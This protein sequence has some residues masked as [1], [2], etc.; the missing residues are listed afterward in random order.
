MGRSPL[1]YMTLPFHLNSQIAK[2]SSC[3]LIPVRTFFLSMV[4][5][6]TF[7]LLP[8]IYNFG[9]GQKTWDRGAGTNNWGDAN[10]WNP[11]GVP[12]ALQT[13]TISRN[14]SYTVD[15]NG[16][17][18]CSSLTISYTGSTNGTI[19]LNVLSTNILTVANGISILNSATNG[20]SNI[21]LNVADA[22]INC[23]NISFTQSTSTT[24]DSY[25]EI[26]DG[27]LYCTG[28][29]SMGATNT[30][31]YALF[32]GN[33][34]LNVGG[35]LTGGTITS[36]AGGGAVAPTSGTVDY[37]GNGA[38]NIGAYTYYNLTISGGNT[39]TLQGTTTVANNL[40]LQQG[41]LAIN[42]NTL[43]LAG[44]VT[45]GG[46]GTGTITGSATSNL[47][48]TGT[49]AFPDFY[50]TNATENLHGLTLNRTGANINLG[51]DLILS[52]TLAL[53]NGII[54]ATGNTIS[55]TNTSAA[56][57]TAGAGSYVDGSIS[58]AMTN[59]GGTYLFP[60]GA[61]CGSHWLT[62]SS[63]SGTNP[64]I[65]ATF[66]CTGAINGDA[67]LVSP[68]SNNVN[69]HLEKVSGTF[70][71]AAVKLDGNEIDFSN[72]IAQ[73]ALQ[74]G[75]YSMITSVPAIGSIT[76]TGIGAIASDKWLA[77][78]SPFIK[79][80]YSYQSGNWNTLS[81][82]T[83]DPSGTLS[84]NSAIPGPLDNVVILNGRT[85]SVTSNIKV[86]NSLEI[87]IGGN[88][89]LTTTNGHDFGTVTGQGVLKL[90]S[91]T[92]P[93]GTFTTFVAAGGGTVEY[94]NSSNFTLSPAQTIYNN[95]IINLS[96]T[97][98]IGN[99]LMSNLT[100]NGTFTV[101]QGQ[102]MIGQNTAYAGDGRV[103]IDFKQ[104]VYV[105]SNGLITVGSASTN[106]TN[107]PASFGTRP[108][109]TG[110]PNTGYETGALVPRYYDI[111][112]TIYIGGNLTNNGSVKFIS[113]TITIPNYTTLTTS[114]A[115]SVRFY[116][117]SNTSLTCNGQ[118][119]FYNLI[120]DK[121]S[122][123]TYTLTVDAAATSNFRLFG[124]NDWGGGG[125][126][127]ANNPELD[128][129][130]WIK[131][132]TLRLTGYVTIP[133]L[134]EGSCAGGSPN[135]DFYIP[136]N[137]GLLVDGPNVTVLTT[138][139]SYLEVNAAYGLNQA[140]NTYNIN[141]TAGCSSFSIYGKFQMNSGFMSTRESG[142]FIFWSNANG[143]FILNGGTIDAKQL[144]SAGGGNG[145]ASFIQSGGTLQLRGRYVIN[146][147][148]ITTVSQIRSAPVNYASTNTGGLDGGVGTFNIK[149]AN[150]LFAMSGGAMNILDVC[151]DNGN[152]FDVRSNAQNN[153]VTGGTVNIN[154]YNSTNYYINTTAPFQN[155][156][157]TR[158]A[159]AATV[160][161]NTALIINNNLVLSAASILNAQN[162]DLSIGGD[163]TLNSGCI[164]TP[165]NNTTTF[166]GSGGQVFTNAGTVTSG[167][168]NF[169]L[170]NASNT[171]IS[172]ALTVRGYLTISNN[173]CY[174][175]D[176][177]SNINVAGNILNSGTHTSQANGG[178][179]LN[180][181]GAQT[182]GGDGTGVFGNI[183]VNNAT[184]PV[185]FTANQTV[186][187][188]L[189]L[190]NGILN[191]NQYS[192]TLSAASNV[193][194]GLAGTT[195]IFSNTKM[196]TT[197]GFQSDGG[198]SK[199]YSTTSPSFVFPVGSGG[200]Y[201]PATIGFSTA[202]IT[203][204]TVNM[205][206]VGF[207]QPITTSVN[208]LKYYWKVTSSGFT[209]IQPNSV[210]HL[211]HFINP[212]DI[213]A[214]TLANYY[215]GVYNP[216]SWTV[217][218]DVS[219][220]DKINYNVKFTG[221]SYLDGDYT[222]GEPGALGTVKVYYSRKS[223]D[224]TDVNTWSSI[225]NTGAVDGTLPGIS[226]NTYNP[227][228]IGDGLSNNHTVTIPVGTNNRIVGALQINT[229]SV[230]DVTTTTGHNFGSLPNQKVTGAGT[231]RISSATNPAVFP[232]GDFGNFLGAGGG[233]V[234]YYST[235]TLG[236]TTFVLPTTYNAGGTNIPIAN[237]NHLL[238][239]PFTGK[240][241]ILPNTDLTVF[242]N[243]GVNGTTITGIAQL[244]I[245]AAHTVKVNGNLNVNSGNLRFMNN[246]AQSLIVT[247]DVTIASGAM[248]DVNNANA[249]TNTMFIQ[250]NLVN[251]GTFNMYQTATRI[252]NVTFNGALNNGISG[253][254][255]IT[256]F[257][258][259]TVNKGADRN[260]VLNVTSTN[261]SLNAALPTALTLTNGTFRLTSPLS[262]TLTTTAAFTIPASGC[263][264]ANGGTIN[265]G[266]ATNNAADLLLQGR[267]EV[268]AGA[269]NI[270]NGSGS[271]NDIEYAAA[272]NP[273][274]VVSGSGTLRVDG[275]IRRNTTN[276][277]GSL[278]YTQSGGIVTVRGLG[279]DSTRGMFEVAN[280]G[281]QFNMSGSG[282]LNIERSGSTTYADALILPASYNVTGGIVQFGN[283][284]TS[285][286]NFNL[287][288][289]S[290]LGSVIVDGTGSNKT[291]SLSV[292][293]LT[294]VNDLTINGTGSVFDCNG[295]DVNIGRNLTNNNTASTVGTIYGGYQPG[296]FTQV[297]TFNGTSAAT[298][299]GVAGNLTNFSN[300][301]NSSTSTVS[302]G[303]NTNI[304]VNTDLT[305]NS[306]ILAD[307]GNTITVI[308]NIEN[309]AIHTSTGS[310]GIVMS[311]N[312]NQVIAG[313][314]AGVFGNVTIDNAQ[315]VSMTD[316][317]TINGSLS[318]INGNLY[319]NDYLLTL[320]VSAS[321]VGTPDATKMILLNGALSD[322]GVRKLFPGTAYDFTFPVG[323]AGKYTPARFNVTSN[324][325]STGTI[326]VKPVNGKHPALQDALVNELAY[327]WYVDTTGFAGTHI[328]EH[329]YT[330][331]PA[332]IT[333]PTTGYLAGRYYNGNWLPTG[334]IIG[335]VVG[336]ST[337]SL[338]PAGVGFIGG[339]YTAGATINF[340]PMS[341][342]YSRQ[343]G[344]WE[345][346]STWFLD[347]PT[348]PTI[349]SVMPNGNQV[350]I[351]NSNNVTLSANNNSAY[352]VD[353]ANSAT[354]T[355]GTSTFHDIGHVSGGGTIHVTSTNDG[356]F[357]FPGGEYDNF[358]ANPLS[359]ITFN[360]PNISIPATMP[361][362]PGNYY[363]PYQN[364][365]FSGAGIKYIT[366]ESLKVLGNLTINGG[367]LSDVLFNRDIYVSGNW[368]DNTATGG[369]VPGTGLV[370]F[371]GT[372]AQN[373]VITNNVAENFYNFRVNNAL[374]INLTSGGAG[375]VQ[376]AN[377]LHLTNGKITTNTTNTFTLTNASPSVVIGGSSASFVNGPLY[378]TINSGSYFNFPVGNGI[379]YG[380][381]NVSSVNT[382]A[383][384]VAQYFNSLS[385]YDVTKMLTPITWVSNNE[386]W[387]LSSSATSNGNVT[388][389]W[390][391]SSFDPSYDRTKLRVVQWN[392]SGAPNPQWESQGSIINDG[393]TTSGT[394]QT[395]NVIDLSPLAN[396]HYLT[397][398]TE[399]KPTATILS[400]T[401]STSICNNATDVATVQIKLTG[402]G[403]WSL[404]YTL[405]GVLTTLTN[406]ASSPVNIAITS[407]S[408][409][410]NNIAG[411]Y[412]FKLT[413]IKDKNGIIGN[414]DANTVAITVKPVPTPSISGR[415][416]VGTSEN[417]VSYSTPS[418]VG[419]TYTWVVTGGTVATGGGTSAI[420]VNWNS[421]AGT[422][423]VQVTETNGAPNNCSIVKI[424]NV[425]KVNAPTPNV[426]GNNN[427]CA[428]A[429]GEIYST[430]NVSTHSYVWTVT[431]GSFTGPT[432]V[433]GNNQVIVSWG[434]SGVGSVKVDETYGSTI[435]STLS[436]SINA[437]PLNTP[438]VA[439]QS[440]CSGSNVTFQITGAEGASDYYLYNGAT[441]I[442]TVHTTTAGNYSF[443]AFI[444]VST[445]T[446]TV[447]VVNQYGC[448]RNLVSTP[449]VT[450]NPLPTI[451]TTGSASTKCFNTGAQT[452]TLAYTATTNSPTSYSIDWNAAAN[453]AGLADQGSTAF[454]FVAGGGS[455]N[456][457]AITAG[458]PGGS[459]SGTMTITNAN[460]C[461]NT[462]A[463]TVTITPTV[464]TP[465]FTLGATS[466]RC[467]GAGAVIYTAT[468]TN[469]TGLTY[470]LDAASLTG[471]NTIN[472]A[473]G[474]VTY[475]ASWSGT[476]II[477]ASA[478]GCNGPKTANHTVTITPTVGTPIFT[479]GPTT[480]RCRG[481][482]TVAYTV[483]ATNT[484]GI[485][486]TL[487]AAS[488]TGGNSIIAATGVVTYIAGWSGSSIITASA[489]GCNG[490]K[491]TIHTA[492]TNDDQVWT[493]AVST[494]WNT[495]GNW[496]CGYIPELTTN[497]Q[498]P[499]VLNKP[500]LG[501]GVIGTVKNIIINTGSSL[502]V[503]GNIL[504]IAGT[505]TNN[506][507][508]TATSGTIEMI[509]SAAQTIGAGVFA[510]NTIEN[511]TISNPS[512]VALSGP[513][514]VTGIV[515]ANG[516]LSS[517]GNLTLVSSATQ[518]ALISGS[519]IANVTGNVTI[520]RYLPSGFGYKYVSSP[521]QTATV[522]EF[523]PEVNLA[524]A[525]E[526]FYTYN[527]NN[528]EGGLG[529]KFIAGW[530]K[531]IVPANPLIP[532]TGYA[533]N[534]GTNPAP[535]P[536][537]ASG[538]VN[539]GNQSITLS[540]N[541][542]PFTKGFNLVG[543]PYP[544][545]I[546]WDQAT[547][548]TLTNVDKAIW[549]FN[550]STT[551]QY[552]GV[553]SSYVNGV[554]TDL[555][556]NATTTPN[557][558][559]SMQGF[560]VHVTNPGSGT[561]AMTNKV[562][563]TNLT[564]TFKAAYFDPRT[565]LRFAANFDEKNSLSDGLVIYFDPLSSV[566][567][568]NEK[569]ALKM[570]NTDLAVPNLY[571]ITPDIH[572]L[573]ISAIPSPIDSL[574]KI[575]L[576]VK[577]LKDGW[578]NF[579]ASDISQ[580]Q[581]NMHIYLTDAQEGITQDLKQK[582]N[583]RFYLKA[584]EYN[585][586]FTLVFSLS[587]LNKPAVVGEKMFTIVRSGNRL[588]VKVNLPFNTKGNLIVT[589]MQGKTLL[590]KGVFEMETVEIDPNVGSG[591]YV[592][593][594]ISGKRIESEK[595]LIRKD[596]E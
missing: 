391:G 83:T 138:A 8:G 135:S 589:N 495:S 399:G 257:N 306:G 37:N 591:V 140:S 576:G 387:W 115:A 96:S 359:T 194:D 102:F 519:G 66:S 149:D 251:N 457:V 330:F 164:Y 331:V 307:E 425:T 48:I 386:Y 1:P 521:F 543:N 321:I 508:F 356:M 305:L 439:N 298:I 103:T 531:Y 384:Y 490:P 325:G 468:A 327:Y 573:S 462:Q 436:V 461:I 385:T 155:L 596:Y 434:A 491:T 61:S 542:R 394:V 144:R 224:W 125:G 463:I 532:M 227:V 302:L 249:A 334:G 396:Q 25:I 71:N 14:G 88:L 130:L 236:N 255:G 504:Q 181:T 160:L 90:S 583:Y 170:S 15:V 347:S 282:I 476:S 42:G 179:I 595:I 32:S 207:I 134:S 592:V 177:G 568:E 317:T 45:R 566:N 172:N 168:N 60:T 119:D 6:V 502:E 19:A 406:Q 308:G 467:Q 17:Y 3:R 82:W 104:D 247:G 469:N 97:A 84:V 536:V 355:I 94:N 11:N 413:S 493:G 243:L 453:T 409:G 132:G 400:P 559:P 547:D 123:Q 548:W 370:S 342:Y 7:L 153:T 76:S 237:Y 180:S 128:K 167:L 85:I 152:V 398:S 252:C 275:Q 353:I 383:T 210:S 287:N 186:N 552:G 525:F 544:S 35:N 545:P 154:T 248:L 303:A 43:N 147:A 9:W 297:T 18:S 187:G 450:V 486:Y 171:N 488:T 466:T 158:L 133:S 59:A 33:G 500:I 328:V 518:T 266:Q 173:D 494:N 574:T 393:G 267:L 191:I 260:S 535:K 276:T 432:V 501:S 294:L 442:T 366:A 455:V 95:L 487:D 295:L 146:A 148:G 16:N 143:I 324:A 564:P 290:P 112:H 483:T 496:S 549:L 270:G 193:Y 572:Q 219:Q 428:N 415:T 430:P 223:G 121:G 412:N 497:V 550:A 301:V 62:L 320:G 4:F 363:K 241:I 314:G 129:A 166:N 558:I 360:N 427:V 443:P 20:G 28:N 587:D 582:S 341:K 67:T 79:T 73:S 335:S 300:F 163:F 309:S 86:V 65:K 401:Y 39:K 174:L 27:N 460:G 404:S 333:T 477:T 478:T 272:G 126:A 397:L 226:P 433:G 40:D 151:Q 418:V 29:I 520:Q 578:A 344:N 594:L 588:Y 388:L 206:P 440:V 338:P 526:T 263:L 178:I 262:I 253:S 89:D 498:I 364:I 499:N 416:T 21:S 505:I 93:A 278:W 239:T 340:A 459:Y 452:T 72:T 283:T 562:R 402:T 316:N 157:L 441:L 512:G 114:G 560:F 485:T 24:S 111:Y 586:R 52:G 454:A 200:A 378:K 218:S 422:G 197:N 376:I 91:G 310:N 99:V 361:L 213:N 53:T 530:V 445:T 31:C 555:S 100:I 350:F 22:T 580:L 523:S 323:V 351:Q 286:G 175:N 47:A 159:G 475:A 141:T 280:S 312:V 571:S 271:N 217:I 315:D 80:Y 524:A 13:V 137:G 336:A 329:T 225:S 319:I 480:S 64:V 419:N 5:L 318:F 75:I 528:S 472:A 198:V 533:A 288:A 268:L 381:V 527:E 514:N 74:A 281:S 326:R 437:L 38:Q 139:D 593:T 118:T 232:G 389:R 534:F 182:I 41:A 503:T 277:L 570:M 509:G 215:P 92:F 304:W 345:S 246:I 438:T 285:S 375:D 405:N 484:T 584:G 49:G 12:T 58:R 68:L 242:G 585:R 256:N 556:A 81:S 162:F 541:N 465:I 506:G 492:T 371:E 110:M 208:A 98:I 540:N 369:F 382:S 354:L 109:T 575:P 203:W 539:N 507:T 169:I 374:G 551:D 296:S 444:P 56:S 120:L 250:G 348:G 313:S 70:T 365:E 538:V 471:L 244:N 165:G 561:L 417:G 101:Q 161:Q 337:I 426:S 332:D 23:S 188:N 407:A 78:G 435:S 284:N 403:P 373:I 395:S 458:T 222:A 46:S 392:P 411:T 50:F 274:I 229:G 449:M 379:R 311:G 346:P 106:N 517:G 185:S 431:G 211:Y 190:A 176:Q 299:I 414:A 69:W 10:N 565:I 87:R 482:G 113:S 557:I 108:F 36:S 590:Q 352:S 145:I 479:L 234:E 456:S 150:N 214:G 254:G 212:A 563:T 464:G 142:G 421:T 209:G 448:S 408:T 196:V 122:D 63:V 377:Y 116:G 291:V 127:D 420:T 51:S 510:G 579:N 554:Y 136:L 423:T 54:S 30:I 183:A 522:G 380:N 489:A 228:I 511:L 537:D 77:I 358:M 216:Y 293:P 569:D 221:V 424:I 339:E 26:N 513:L 105:S 265:I 34:A 410:I 220:I 44:A 199:T 233:M 473:T 205:K 451:S 368:T 258:I 553:Y 474:A 429:T 195:A 117:Q 55:L 322:Q 264:S 231:L 470:T 577:V 446:Y 390:D 269:V 515:T 201:H 189:R 107:L 57:V 131:N 202:P 447:N 567:F 481:A 529:I 240:N 357:V 261:F 581:S 238:L 367:T 204:G 292:N 245:G 156:N 124:R 372:I 349:A 273:E 362:K 289:S 192:L 259:L 230:L 343:T 235:T 516:N 279:F 184:G 546:D 2:I